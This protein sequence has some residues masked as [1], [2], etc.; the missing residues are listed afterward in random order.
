MTGNG[1]IFTTGRRLVLSVALFSAIFGF[2]CGIP[3]LDPPECA[4][5]RT[6][7]REFYSYHFGN[8]MKFSPE[9]LKQRERFLSP[10]LVAELR[11]S[12]EGTDPFTTGTDDLPKAF[13]AGKCRTLSPDRTEFDLLIFWK[14][15]IRNEQRSMKVEAVKS[16]DT[17]LVDKIKR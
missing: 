7:V 9:G 1:G 11:A 13:R 6:A 2:G 12:K 17:W 5:S 16:G 4:A 10:A 3:N 8:D 14:D 15:D